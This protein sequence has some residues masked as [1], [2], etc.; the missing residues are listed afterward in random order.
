M[1]PLFL[2]SV[3]LGVVACQS[4][5]ATDAATAGPTPPAQATPPITPPAPAPAA[6]PEYVEV[7]MLTVNGKPR[8]QLSTKLLTSQLGRPDSIARGVVEC[9]GELEPVNNANGDFWYY[10]KTCYEVA[11]SQ[12]VLASFNVTSGRF[13]GKLG[14]LLLNQHTTLEDVRRF[15]PL[16]AKQAEEPASGRPGEVM[17]LPF[18]YKG[19]PMDASLHLLFNKGRLQEVE[20]F[21]PC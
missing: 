21:N 13:Q 4:N 18:F 12:A 17:S 1:K 20:F 9:G 2:V 16:S 15:F 5:P 19:A 14:K 6:N 8:E 11:G 7:D 3:L 10:G